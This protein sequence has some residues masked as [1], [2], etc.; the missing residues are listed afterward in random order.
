METKVFNY[1]IWPL[2]SFEE[3]FL[4][5]MNKYILC[6]CKFDDFGGSVVSKN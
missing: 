6:Q 5:D 2:G 4:Y 3:L 1:K